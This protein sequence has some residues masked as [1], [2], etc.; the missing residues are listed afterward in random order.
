[1][2][3]AN[4]PVR[5]STHFDFGRNWAEYSHLIDERAVARAK[6]GLDKLG[7]RD[8][9]G[10]TFLDIGSGSGI[11]SLAAARSGAIVSAID[12]DRDSVETTNATLQKGGLQPCARQMSVFD[13]TPDRLGTF[14]IVYSWGVLHH[15]GDVWRALECAA[16][17]VAPGGLLAIGLY[18]KTM[19]CGA[20]TI[21]KRLYT[22]LPTFV[23]APIK[24]V[25]G[26]VL[27]A[28]QSA[29]RGIGPRRFVREYHLN[30]GMSFWHDVDDWLGGYPYQST[31]ASD[32][33]SFLERLGFE[34]VV[35]HALPHSVGVFAS[36]CSEFTFR[37]KA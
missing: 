4:E 16:A 25:F 10:K 32:V 23:R 1:M 17:L 19:L 37:R 35:D 15:T 8:L 21:E 29:K 14:D 22:R 5:P 36:G 33:V 9:A 2:V 18:E 7:L 13:A 30:R 34:I 26:S 11:H 3:T 31:R 24:A 28:T 12:V 27:L 20:W 6:S